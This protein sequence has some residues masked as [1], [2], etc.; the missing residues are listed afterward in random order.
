VE[1]FTSPWDAHIT[2]GLLESEGIPASLASE[3]H[4]WANW[5]FSLA[6][7]GVRLQVPT[8]F[9]D[10]AQDVL[11]KQ[12]NGEY[13]LALEEQQDFPAV[14]CDRCGSTDLRY[15]RSPWSMLLLIA[16]A[17][18]SGVIFPPGIKGRKCNACKAR[19]PGAL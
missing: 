16:T 1:S 19:L 3:H 9:A 11:R 17:G 14:R 15:V 2:R 12:R 5:P 10:R 18:L 8:E 4:V 7:G 13:Q 6:L